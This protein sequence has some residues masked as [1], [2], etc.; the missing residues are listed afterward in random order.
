MSTSDPNTLIYERGSPEPNTLQVENEALRHGF[1]LIPN[2]VLR[3][4]NLSRDAK[5]LYGILLSYAWQKGSCFPG[6]ETLMQDLRCAR[7]ALAKYIKELRTT[8]FVEVKRRGQGKTSIY[9]IKDVVGISDHTSGQKFE[10]RTSRSSETEPPAV[11]KANGE[12]YSGKKTQKEENPDIYLSNGKATLRDRLTQSEPDPAPQRQGRGVTRLSD[13]LA[14]APSRLARA[15]ANPDP[16][17]SGVPPN[18]A[19]YVT[20][21]SRELHDSEH[22]KSNITQAFRLMQQT[23]LSETA[24]MQK[25]T[26]ARA[27]T[28]ERGNIK[29]PASQYGEFGTKNKAPYWFAVLRDLLGMKEKTD[30]IEG[31]QYRP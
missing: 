18:L 8:G 14:D 16:L 6:Y 26:E 24:F 7:E 23:G 17:P 4:P 3:A 31:Y 5:L 29:K 19:H 2:A 13:A 12:E 11:R 20:A 22:V 27:I 9:I 10:N 25:L 1:T 15:R 30:H 21:W 28:K